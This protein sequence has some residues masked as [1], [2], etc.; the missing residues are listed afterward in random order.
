MKRFCNGSEF[1][2]PTRHGIKRWKKKC[3]LTQRLLIAQKWRAH[4]QPST[5]FLDTQWK[6]F[7]RKIGSENHPLLCEQRLHFRGIMS[8]FSF[9]RVSSCHE[10]GASAHRVATQGPAHNHLGHIRRCPPQSHQPFI[11]AGV[12]VGAAGQGLRQGPDCGGRV[13]WMI[14]FRTSSLPV[15]WRLSFFY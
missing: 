8:Y 10:K 2:G 4:R 13:G 6:T 7:T 14:S 15:K 1:V 5:H 12:R 3:C 11:G 9:S